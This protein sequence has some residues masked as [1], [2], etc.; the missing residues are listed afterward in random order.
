VAALAGAGADVVEVRLP[1]YLEVCA[2]GK[3]TQISEALTVHL[4]TIRANG[5]GYA[6]A[7]RAY[8]T[9]GAGT[10]ATD[11]LI[12]QRIRRTGRRQFRELFATVDI[13][14]T[15]TTTTPAPMLAALDPYDLA[16]TA[17]CYHTGYWSALGL[18]AL[19]VPIGF[20]AQGLPLGMQIA[21]HRHA[22][23]L[24]LAAGHAYQQ[25]T[26]WHTRCPP[27]IAG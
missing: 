1:L 18:P 19:S 23:H 13:V 6:T 3:L 25:L 10:T 26:D 27:T 11:Y 9:A 12:A 20:T 15:P 17:G 24:V 8:L 14:V 16:G 22:D 2:A 7:S 5:S 21:G 4:P